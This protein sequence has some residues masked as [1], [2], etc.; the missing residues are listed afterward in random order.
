MVRLS[1]CYVLTQYSKLLCSTFTGSRFQVLTY[2]EML[3]RPPLLLQNPVLPHTTDDT[4]IAV[5]LV[6][7][8]R[9]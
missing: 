1:T 4:K 5:T 7:T 2:R 3:D 6:A 9:I 8:R